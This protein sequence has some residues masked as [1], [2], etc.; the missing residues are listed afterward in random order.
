MCASAS[1]EQFPQRELALR[2]RLQV[3]TDRAWARGRDMTLLAGAALEGGATMIQLREKVAS[4]RALIEEGQRL[5]ALT[6]RHGALLIVNDRVD[7]ALAVEADGLHVG[8]GDMPVSLARRLLGAECIIGVSVANLAEAEQAIS[9]GADYLS[10]S[11]VFA[12]RSK[13]DAGAGLGLAVA[14]EIARYSPLPV[15]AIGGIEEENV[16]S[17][18]RAGACGVAVI[19]AVIGAED[20]AAAARRLRVAIDTEL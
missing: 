18:I 9:E 2:L 16:A 14:G 1:S 4:T 3:L 5:R 6:R 19:S 10:V 20:V 12:T 7:V 11:P 15:I 17:V 8:Q 13:A